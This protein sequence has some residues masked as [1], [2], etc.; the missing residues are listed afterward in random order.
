M[1][2]KSIQLKNFDSLEFLGINNIPED[3]KSNFR[4]SLNNQI[5]EYIL[6][7][8]LDVLPDSIDNELENNPITNIRELERFLELRVPRYKELISKFLIAFREKYY[9]DQY[10]GTTISE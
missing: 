6:V 10:S 1:D 4:E 7:N 2:G 8:I 9:N 3:E 5:S